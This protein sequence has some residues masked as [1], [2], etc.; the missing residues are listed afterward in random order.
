[1]GKTFKEAHDDS[2]NKELYAKRK[3]KNRKNKKMSAYDKTKERHYQ[4]QYQ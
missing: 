1:M 2:K 3:T 4:M